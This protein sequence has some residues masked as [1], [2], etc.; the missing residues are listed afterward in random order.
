MIIWQKRDKAGW[1]H[2]VSRFI[3]R[4]YRLSPTKFDARRKVQMQILHTGTNNEFDL[5]ICVII[6][7]ALKD[8]LVQKTNECL[9]DEV[10]LCFN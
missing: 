3:Y 2:A 4:L 6:W 7:L 1:D 9:V 5:I 8:D 10:D